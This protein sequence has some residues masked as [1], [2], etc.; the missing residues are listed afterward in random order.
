MLKFD[1]KGYLQPSQIIE[2][3]LQT[4]QLYFVENFELSETRRNIFLDYFDFIQDFRNLI[5]NDTMH[6]LNGSFVSKKLN[7]NDMDIVVFIDYEVYEAKKDLIEDKFN[8]LRKEKKYSYLDIYT[9]KVYPEKHPF[10]F[11]YLSDKAYWNDWFSKT[12]LDKQR[13]QYHKGFIQL[14]F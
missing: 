11:F 6:W 9:V 10:Y 1:S 12:R 5:S 14:N 3:D 7:P 2:T 13:K 8:N 4:F